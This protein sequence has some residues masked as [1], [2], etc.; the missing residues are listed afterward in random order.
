MQNGG[1]TIQD[2]GAADILVGIPTYNNA[3]TIVPLI[4][5]A[6]TGVMQFPEHRT[7]IM[8]VDGGSEDSTLQSART[9]LNGWS[10]FIQTSYPLYPIHKIAVSSHA[11]P[12]R[13]SAFQTI[14]STAERLGAQACCV[15]EPGL[16]SVPPEWI[17]SL[18][19][20]VLESGFDLVAPQYLRHKYEG[21]LIS[22]ILYPIVR[23]LFGKQ[24]RQ[25]VGS[26]FGFSRG[27]IRHCL[28]QNECNHE[29]RRQ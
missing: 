12:G 27:F 2:V 16:K 22:G 19:Q 18:V 26:D 17:G 28:S 6:R 10:N 14:F 8:Q 3:D 1:A 25:P 24:I 23:A 20:P 21:T 7:V 29:I 13:D 5:A 15:I 11:I 4:N 9:A